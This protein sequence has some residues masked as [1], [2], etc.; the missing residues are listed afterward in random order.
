[1]YFK[2]FALIFDSKTDMTWAQAWTNNV[3]TLEICTS[4]S[5]G[6]SVCG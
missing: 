5:R 3:R 6:S 4:R 2:L 1:M